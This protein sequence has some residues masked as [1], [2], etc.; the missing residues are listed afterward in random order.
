MGGF[1][2]RAASVALLPVL[3]YLVFLYFN[4]KDS[5]R[6]I[7]EKTSPQKNQSR[8]ILLKGEN[9]DD[10][11]ETDLQDILYLQAH[12]NYVMLYLEHENKVQR[13]ILRSTLK[14]LQQQLG[15]DAFPKVHRS[16]VVNRSKIE[17]IK[18]NKSKAKLKISGIDKPIPLSRSFYDS[19]KK[20]A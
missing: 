13:H 11:V 3:I 19:I 20:S 10:R 6:S 4:W 9:K 15:N 7:L 1:L 17:E 2:S 18:G 14:D 8:Q 16:Y 5:Y 12:D